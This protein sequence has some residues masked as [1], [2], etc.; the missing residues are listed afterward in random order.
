MDSSA[1]SGKFS[2]NITTWIIYQ[3]S[4]MTSMIKLLQS[5]LLLGIRFNIMFSIKL[6]TMFRK[7]LAKLRAEKQ[8]C[9]RLATNLLLAKKSTRK[10][11]LYK[12]NFNKEGESF[13]LI[14]ISFLYFH[15]ALLS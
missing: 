7:Y 4:T 13:F 5:K 15:N 1:E 6:A 12:S 3:D 9:S 10:W 11:K 2:S 8:R 14:L